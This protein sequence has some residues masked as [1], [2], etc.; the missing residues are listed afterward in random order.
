MY[1]PFFCG[2]PIPRAG[3]EVQNSSLYNIP[4]FSAIIKGFLNIFRVFP[5]ICE[6]LGDCIH[7]GFGFL[8]KMTRGRW[9]E[10]SRGAKLQPAFLSPMMAQPHSL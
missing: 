5:D 9:D 10:G 4:H 2:T 1:P 8:Y 3:M 7:K 6:A